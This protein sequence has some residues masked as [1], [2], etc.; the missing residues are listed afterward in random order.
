MPSV[1]VNDID[2][3]YEIHGSGHPL[4]LIAGLVSDSQSWKPAVRELEKDFKVIIFDNRGIG[5]TRY[6][7][8]SFSISTLAADTIGLLDKLGI[9]KSDILGHSM[10]GFIAQEIAIEYPERVNKLILANSCVCVSQK[11]RSM[12]ASFLKI[13]EQD[14]NYELFIREFFKLIFTPGYLNNKEIIEP[15]IKS[16]VQYSFP[17]TVEGFKLQLEAIGKFH[18][19]E[20]LNKIK[21]KTLILAGKNDIM[22]TAEETQ[23]LADKIP[24]A[25]I[26]F[27]ENAAHSFQVE[28]PGSFVSYLNKFLLDEDK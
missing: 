27:M 8:T 4:L 1:K 7:K 5:R 25:K 9:E 14:Q 16:A 11:N 10:G 19:Q 18:S 2:C 28:D 21:A 24:G 3:Y 6:P 23:L 22:V 26:L 12:F 15:A 20:R 13:L 17:V